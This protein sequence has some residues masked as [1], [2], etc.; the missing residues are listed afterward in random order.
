[1]VESVAAL[2]FLYNRPK[3]TN[4]DRNWLNDHGKKVEIL[5][6]RQFFHCVLKTYGLGQQRKMRE[7]SPEYLVAG[8]RESHGIHMITLKNHMTIKRLD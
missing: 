2:E 3:S 4:S 7:E 5:T 6:L 1:M 8:S